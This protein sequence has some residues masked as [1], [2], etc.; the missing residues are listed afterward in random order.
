MTLFVLEPGAALLDECR[1]P[2]AHVLGLGQFDEYLCRILQAVINGHL[3]ALV[4]C[5]E[6]GADCT[7]NR[8]CCSGFCDP[9]TLTCRQDITDCLEYGMPCQLP[10]E[11]CSGECSEGFCG[12]GG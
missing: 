8:D 1:Y 5:L 9:S 3:L 12:S 7:T 10:E 6:D 4:D 2:F 11:C